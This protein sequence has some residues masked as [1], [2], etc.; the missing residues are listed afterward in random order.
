MVDRTPFLRWC[1]P[2]IKAGS[3]VPPELA[4]L[5]DPR[6]AR[7]GKDPCHSLVIVPADCGAGGVPGVSGLVSA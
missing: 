1:W 3:K 7:L 2:Y 5:E 4:G 6:E